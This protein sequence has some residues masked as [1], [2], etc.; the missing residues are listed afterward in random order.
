M[1]PEATFFDMMLVAIR[2]MLC[3]V[4]VTSRRAYM[5]RSAGTRSAV[6]PA[7]AIPTRRTWSIRRCGSRSTSKPGD[8]LEL[9]ERAAGVA[10]AAA[11]ELGD[12][13]AAGRH[14]RR[15]DERRLVADAAGRVLVGDGPANR[16]QVEPRARADHRPHQV[17]RLARRSCRAA[18]PP[19]G[20]RP[21]G[22]RACRPR[23][24]RPA[25]SARELA[26]VALARDQIDDAGGH[27]TGVPGRSASCARVST[28]IDGRAD[29]GEGVAVVAPGD[30]RRPGHVGE[31][32]GVLPGVVGRGRRRVAAVIGGQDQQVAVAQRGRACRAGPRRTPR[33]ASANPR[34]SL[35]WPHS[36]SVSTRFTNTKLASG[37]VRR[38]SVVT[39]IP[40]PFDV[41]GRE[42]STSCPAKMSPILPTP[43]TP[44]PRSRRRSR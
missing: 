38:S 27:S 32:Q 1:A 21:A 26:A 37:S 16:C 23:S 22:S 3:T 5:R 9:V 20:T 41:V 36:M 7:T 33:G 35:R 13:H 40:C 34:G 18:R 2:G 39:A 6:C 14:E 4:A 43:C 31:Q 11:G 30:H 25:R 19:S 15:H 28:R 42:V 12:R 44:I 10:E 8:R 29:V 17:G 24:S